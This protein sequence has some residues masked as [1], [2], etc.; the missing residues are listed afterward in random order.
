MKD[1]KFGLKITPNVL[2]APNLLSHYSFGET[3]ALL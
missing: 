2:L 1:V 3:F